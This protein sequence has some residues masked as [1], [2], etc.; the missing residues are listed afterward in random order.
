M[1]ESAD[2]WNNEV[3]QPMDTRSLFHIPSK[4]G[5]ELIYFCGNSLGLQPKTTST[6]LSKVLQEWQQ[7]AVDGWWEAKPAWLELNKA[8][9]ST[10]A[11]I[12]GA[13]QEEVVTMNS[14]TVNVHLLLASFYNPQKQKNKVLVEA[15]LFP[16]DLYAL[17]SHLKSRNLDPD[18]NIIKVSPRSGQHILHTEDVIDAISQH[19]D[20]LALI[21]W[22]GVNY[23]TG[24]YYNLAEISRCA[25]ELDITIGL[26]L[27]HAA[28]NVP[29]HLHDWGV[30]CA[31]W[32]TYKYLNAGPGAVSQVFVHS[33]HHEKM[34]ALTGWWGVAREEQFL[35]KD[36]FVP[37]S[38]ADAYQVSTSNIL[39]VTSL[40]ASLELFD[41]V[42][43][44]S[45]IKRNRILS[46][47]LVEGVKRI[48]SRYPNQNI[49][50]LTPENESDRGAQVSISFGSQ[51]KALFEYLIDN[52]VVVDWREPDIIRVAPCGW[53]NNVAE[54]SSFLKIMEGFFL[55]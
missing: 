45:I 8:T 2:E 34:P 18:E 31:T 44:N 13:L 4:N 26:D 43:I 53:Y 12:V 25:N 21:W 27:A 22:S 7:L 37:A 15:D 52:G 39:S 24:Q 54:I 23:K 28:G 1:Q 41:Q 50:L 32:C 33:K 30:D 48:G 14:L 20:E 55:Q 38:G 36:R 16:S 19:A 35:M 6:A 10:T 51:G 11:S 49:Q 17:Q 40:R 29:L 5:K 47:S 3:V 42:G 9:K 46:S